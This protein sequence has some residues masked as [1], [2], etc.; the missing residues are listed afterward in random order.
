MPKSQFAGPGKSFPVNDAIHAE[1]ALQFVGRSA[2]A[3]N[4]TPM[5]AAII[6]RKAKAKLATGV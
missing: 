4:I 2:A 3:G 1:K 5:Q 6:K